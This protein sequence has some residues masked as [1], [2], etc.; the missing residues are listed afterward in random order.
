VLLLLLSLYTDA[1]LQSLT[2]L[3]YTSPPTE[4]MTD[5]KTTG[6]II[7]TVLCCSVYHCCSV[8]L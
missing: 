5:W 6:K 7:R 4:M 1:Y 8:C 3:H 2:K